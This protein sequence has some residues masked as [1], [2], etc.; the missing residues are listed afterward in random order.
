MKKNTKPFSKLPTPTIERLALY[1]RPLEIYL[2]SGIPV[3]S[4]EILAKHCGVNPAQV[5]KD[6]AHFG[7]FGVRGVGYEVSTLLK[8]IKKILSTDRIWNICIVGLGNLGTALAENQN[9]AKRGYEFVAAFD[10]DP[11]KIGKYLPR[12]LQI[13]P[14]EKIPE[15]VEKFK[16]EIGIITTPPQQAQR[17]A[18]WLFSA[19][20][21][22]I[23]NFAPIQLRSPECCI[24]ENVDFSVNLENLAYHLA[25]LLEE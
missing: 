21:K 25:N 14:V 22:A 15:F 13:Q 6:L 17:V 1:T 16:I 11:E 10:T 9:F 12:G 23:L 20:I 5:R 2:K 3:I 4:S 19:G 8:E 24:V 7:E 18:E